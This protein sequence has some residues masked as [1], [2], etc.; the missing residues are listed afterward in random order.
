[1]SLKN[2]LAIADES[3]WEEGGNVDRCV[4]GGFTKGI[5]GVQIKSL[6]FLAIFPIHSVRFN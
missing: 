6:N 4:E 1:M 2:W 5:H 3:V